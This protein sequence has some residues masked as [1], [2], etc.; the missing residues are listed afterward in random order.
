MNRTK[1]LISAVFPLLPLPN[2]TKMRLPRS[3]AT[4]KCNSWGYLPLASC[5]TT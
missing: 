2:R 4:S 5:A 1:V 3:A